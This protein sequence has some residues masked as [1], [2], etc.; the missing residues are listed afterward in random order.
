MINLWRPKFMYQQIISTASYSQSVGECGVTES[1]NELLC[2]SKKETRAVQRAVCRHIYIYSRW[3]M[4]VLNKHDHICR[5]SKE[6]GHLSPSQV[7]S[8]SV[9]SVYCHAGPTRTVCCGKDI[10]L[11]FCEG[12]GEEP[13]HNL[14]YHLPWRCFVSFYRSDVNGPHL[15]TLNLVLQH[16]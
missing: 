14:C 11:C 6:E 4:E 9:L 16:L 8:S 2:E 3:I 5:L 12:L 15:T 13:V 7:H 1:W 10:S